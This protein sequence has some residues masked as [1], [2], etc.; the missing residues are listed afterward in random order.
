M[1]P[2]LKFHFLQIWRS[3]L[4]ILWVLFSFIVQYATVAIMQNATFTSNEVKHGFELRQVVIVLLYVQFFTGTVLSTVYGIWV[5]PYLH[6]EPRT[7]LTY[8]LPITKWVFPAVYAV[9]FAGLVLLQLVGWFLSIAIRYGFGAF[10]DPT[11]PWVE[12]GSGVLLVLVA[13]TTISF[14]LSVVSM[15]FGKIAA[16]IGGSFVAFVLYVS[17]GFF[18]ANMGAESLWRKIYAFMPPLGEVI[19]DLQRGYVWEGTQLFHFGLWIGWLLL[20]ASLFRLRLNKV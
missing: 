6:E 11:F 16:F 1:I 8:V 19:F 5:L 18:Q 9:S 3:R 15:L 14:A 12:V 7:A 13:L 20:L 4:L 2:L 17:A 10:A